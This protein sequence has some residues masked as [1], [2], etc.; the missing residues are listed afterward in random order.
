MLSN[1]LPKYIA[2]LA[3]AGAYRVPSTDETPRQCPNFT[4]P[5]R[6]KRR[7]Q[8]GKALGAEFLTRGMA[9]G[10]AN[11]FFAM[12]LLEASGSVLKQTALP[13]VPKQRP[14]RHRRGAKETLLLCMVPAP[15]DRRFESRVRNVDR[16]TVLAVAMIIGVENDEADWRCIFEPDVC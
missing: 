4:A 12:T 1:V 11:K 2:L 13:S 14:A 10:P 6:K 3:P 7:P 5:L 16:A 8:E 9:A 15:L